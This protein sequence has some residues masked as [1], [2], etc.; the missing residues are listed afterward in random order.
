MKRII[1]VLFVFL[2]QVTFAQTTIVLGD[3]DDVKVF[4]QL[5]VTLIASNETKAVINGPEQSK[6]EIINKNGLL[7]IKMKTRRKRMKPS[8]QPTW[9]MTRLKIPISAG[10][11]N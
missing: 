3:F 5:K 2:A 1:S 11:M 6:V 4:D 7:K 10:Y 9:K 8:A